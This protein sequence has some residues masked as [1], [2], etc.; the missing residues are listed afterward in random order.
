MANFMAPLDKYLYVAL[1]VSIGLLIMFR[2]SQKIFGWPLPQLTF[3]P[4]YNTYIA[5]PIQLI[6][7]ACIVIGLMTRWC[8][9]VC[10]GLML[11]AY[12]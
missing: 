5:G 4:E 8:A 2:G 10:G 1:R 6:G 9:F 7:G 12:W 3:M 11:F